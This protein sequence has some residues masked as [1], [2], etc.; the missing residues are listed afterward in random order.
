[1]ILCTTCIHL[2]T[3][4]YFI[5]VIKTGESE[6]VCRPTHN[7][8]MGSYY[9]RAQEYYGLIGNAAEEARVRWLGKALRMTEKGYWIPRKAE[10]CIDKVWNARSMAMNYSCERAFANLRDACTLHSRVLEEEELAKY[11]QLGGWRSD[12]DWDEDLQDR[13]IEVAK[14]EWVGGLPIQVQNNLQEIRERQEEKW[15][16]EETKMRRKLYAQGY[17][18]A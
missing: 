12:A 16:S 5:I 14:D 10:Y 15:L 13:E 9:Q 6:R 8:S 7:E 11:I 2:L 4:L 18:V 17:R 3:H 1:M